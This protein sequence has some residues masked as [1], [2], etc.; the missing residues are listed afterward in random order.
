MLARQR[1]LSLLVYPLFVVQIIALATLA[2]VGMVNLIRSFE[3]RTVVAELHREAALIAIALQSSA[4]ESDVAALV[5]QIAATH[6]LSIAIARASGPPLLSTDPNAAEAVDQVRARVWQ[7]GLAEIAPSRDQPAVVGRLI[8]TAPALGRVV[9]VVERVPQRSQAARRIVS[10]WLVAIVSGTFTTVAW[11]GSRLIKTVRNPMVVLH[12]ATRHF[13]EGDL[14][15]R[16]LIREPSEF[17][18]LA[19][20]LNAMAAQLSERIDAV[21][22]QRNQISA[23][24]R[25]MNEGLILVDERNQVQM[26]NDAARDFFHVTT[27]TSGNNERRTLLEVVRN[28][29]IDSFVARVRAGE[30][31]LRTRATIYGA[32][33]RYF[34]LS[35]TTLEVVQGRAV[36][37]VLSDITRIEELENIR[38]DFVANVS[39]ELK[40]PLTSILGYVETLLDGQADTNPEDA[41]RFLGKIVSH[42]QRLHALVE[43]LLQLSRLEQQETGPETETIRIQ[44]VIANVRDMVGRKAEEK[45]IALRA[46]YEGSTQIEADPRL[47]EQAI[48]NLVEN[49]IKYCPDGSE[50]SFVSQRSKKNV[51]LTVQDNGPGIPEEDRARVF[52]RFYRVDRGRNSDLGGTGL[53]LSIVKHIAQAHGGTVCLEESE[54]GGSAFTIELPQPA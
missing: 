1:T 43:D 23:I 20:T 7:T 25:S 4:S 9:L 10:W 48:I 36:L 53:G 29:E 26:M 22:E 13:A 34:Q 12:E 54:S 35:G 8:E 21:S 11:V 37:V 16:C 47:L 33:K 5:D 27:L 41:K 3:S 46:D 30:D 24:L 38:R 42:T 32:N 31:P 28:T 52:E 18:Q 15:Y 44:D 14:R 39:H 17:S 6:L 49:A 2:S 51:R 50:I 19:E 45:H 40:T